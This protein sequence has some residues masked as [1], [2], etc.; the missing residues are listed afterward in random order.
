[1]S[2][3]LIE[4]LVKNCSEHFQWTTGRVRVKRGYGRMDG[5]TDIRTDGYP[6]GRI[7]VRTDIR[8]D[9]YPYGRISVRTDIRTDGYPYGRI[10]YGWISGRTDIRTDGR[11]GKARM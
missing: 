7:S 11:E 8:T 3:P 2:R 4:Q 9:G 6:Y 5:R 10:S 1:M